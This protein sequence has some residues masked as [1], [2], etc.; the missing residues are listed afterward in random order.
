MNTDEHR[1]TDPASLSVSIHLHPR[2]H[3]SHA[4]MRAAARADGADTIPANRERMRISGKIV[5]VQSQ[6]VALLLLLAGAA[7]MHGCGG[8][9]SRDLKP[10]T[11]TLDEFAGPP[12]EYPP[13]AQTAPADSAPATE[14][15][16][17][18]DEVEA[19]SAAATSPATQPVV[20]LVATGSAEPRRLLRPGEPVIV[21]SVIG[22]VAGR[23]IFADKFLAAFNL[24][25]RLRAMSQQLDAREFT[26]AAAQIINQ[27][28]HEQV[29]NDLFLAESQASLTE[30]QKM[31]LLAFMQRLREDVIGRG[32][33][34]E[35]FTQSELAEQGMTLDQYLALERDRTLIGALIR[36]KITPRVI[37]SWKEVEREYQRRYAEFNPPASVTLTRLRLLADQRDAIEQVKARLAAGED[38]DAVASSVDPSQPTTMGTFAVDMGPGGILDIK[39]VREEYRPKLI[40]LGLG[41]TTA[42]IETT[43]WVLWLHVQA[44]DQPPRQTLYQVQRDLISQLWN[45]RFT[46]ERRRYIN[47]LFEKGIY[48][49]MPEMSHRVLM[50]ALMRYSP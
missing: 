2:F 4:E 48:D 30:Q 43:D 7:M 11:V 24:D 40:G 29:L 18:A 9:S 44:V 26:V 34:S 21:E 37:V 20:P 12:P 42:P 6:V 14:A 35:L 38:F 32:R 15:S 8:P 49:A 10:R 36:E 13:S 47:S 5:N 39:D 31:G 50:V 23:P 16:T 22:Q 19:A 27:Q 46:D 25:E 1:L 41:Q 45:Q 33:G 17:S 3:F 28:L